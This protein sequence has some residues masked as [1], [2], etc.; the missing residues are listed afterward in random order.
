MTFAKF[1]Q[2]SDKITQL[3]AQVPR[4]EF[5]HETNRAQHHIDAP[6]T[7]GHGQ[8]NSQPSTVA[9]MLDLLD[10]QPGQKVL[11]IGSGSGWTTALLAHLVGEAGQVIGVE[12]LADLVRFGQEN[13]ARQGLAQAEIRPAIR[14]QFGLI[15]EGPFDRILVSAE[16]QELPEELMDQLAPNGV[17]V[18]PVAGK[19]HRIVKNAE[20][21]TTTTL[22]GGFRFV[23]LVR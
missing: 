18:I 19:M 13:L 2:P 14:G 4:Q 1:D 5:L 16:P 8:T 10:V 21:E 22:H 3:M 12:R 15:D 6:L 11:D 23:P 7:I 9:F 20:G 17:L